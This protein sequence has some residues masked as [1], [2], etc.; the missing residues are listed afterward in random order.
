MRPLI[1]QFS[2][3]HCRWFVLAMK[4][5]DERKKP[6]IVSPTFKI[7]HIPGLK[8]GSDSRIEHREIG[9]QSASIVRSFAIEDVGVQAQRVVMIREIELMKVSHRSEAER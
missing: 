2:I 4:P 1:F 3:F 8:S 5:N 6:D 7:Q 9:E